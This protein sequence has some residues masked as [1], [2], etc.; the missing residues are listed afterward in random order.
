MQIKQTYTT[1]VLPLSG[2]VRWGGFIGVEAVYSARVVLGLDPANLNLDYAKG[3]DNPKDNAIYNDKVKVYP[4]PAT[5]QISLAFENE[6]QK[7]AV[8]ELYD[9]N[10][11][12]IL[13]KTI[14]AKT[15]F[16][17]INLNAVKAGIYYYK[18]IMAD[19]II[20]NNKLVIINR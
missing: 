6:L 8:F 16:N 15:V 17:T 1:G 18:L 5:N 19:E 14:Q 10:G 9:F 11:K 3:S 20:A 4:N 2:E 13:S 12:L 7:E